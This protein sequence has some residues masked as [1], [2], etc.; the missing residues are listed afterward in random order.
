MRSTALNT[1][2]NVIDGLRCVLALH[3][4]RDV[5]L[6]CVPC[7][8]AYRLVAEVRQ[9][10]LCEDVPMVFCVLNCMAREHQREKVLLSLRR[11]ERKLADEDR[12]T[13]IEDDTCC[14]CGIGR[15][16]DVTDLL[17]VGIEGEV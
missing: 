1:S 2:V 4:L 16:T 3:Q 5:L 15:I 8:F 14:S 9:E 13:L 11:I 17:S 10:V 6:D 12:A 7:D